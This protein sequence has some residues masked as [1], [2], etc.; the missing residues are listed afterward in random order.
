MTVCVY[1][2]FILNSRHIVLCNYMWSNWSAPNK[3][4]SLPYSNHNLLS[5]GDLF[6]SFLNYARVAVACEKISKDQAVTDQAN[7]SQKFC[8]FY[9]GWKTVMNLFEM[10]KLFKHVVLW[11]MRYHLYNFKS[12]YNLQFKQPY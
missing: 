11:A 12:I 7:I 4:R 1:V 3:N 6:K 2:F 10:M 8:C 9:S 5:R